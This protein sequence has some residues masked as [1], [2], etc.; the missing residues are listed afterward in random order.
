VL[1]G[2]ND[3]RASIVRLDANI[4]WS[5]KASPDQIVEKVNPSYLFPIM[6]AYIQATLWGNRTFIALKSRL[7][8]DNQISQ[9]PEWIVDAEQPRHWNGS[10]AD[11]RDFV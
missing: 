2:G 8:S 4:R 3:I 7:I 6:P 9:R 1:D 11:N 5:F 10:R